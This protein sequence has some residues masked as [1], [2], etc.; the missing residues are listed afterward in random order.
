MYHVFS[1]EYIR[2][3]G[4]SVGPL[5]GYQGHA[6][7][8]EDAVKHANAHVDNYE[9]V[10]IVTTDVDRITIV[11]SRTDG[12]WDYERIEV[13]ETEEETAY[14]EQMQANQADIAEQRAIGD[15]TTSGESEA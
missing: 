10:T 9:D 8:L 12:E 5:A 14:N 4:W 7:T 3:E 11:A 1:A 15:E 6:D 13:L 2:Y